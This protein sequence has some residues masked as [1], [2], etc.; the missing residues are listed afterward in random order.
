MTLARFTGTLLVLLAT[1]AHVASSA[2][3][4]G[5]TFHSEFRAF[6]FQV[7]LGTDSKHRLQSSLGVGTPSSIWKTR[8]I[9]YSLN[10]TAPA[11]VNGI[12]AAMILASNHIR[13]RTCVNFYEVA[14]SNTSVD[15]VIVGDGPGGCSAGGRVLNSAG[16]DN[17]VQLLVHEMWHIIGI[18]HEHMRGDNNQVL[19]QNLTNVQ[20]DYRSQFTFTNTIFNVRDPRSVMWYFETS[21]TANGLPAYVS[22]YQDYPV[23]CNRLTKADAENAE[24]IT[25]HCRIAPVAPRCMS[26]LGTAQLTAT[27]IG[28]NFRGNLSLIALFNDEVMPATVT[29]APS[30][31]TADIFSVA[32][33]RGSQRIIALHPQSSDGNTSFLVNVTWNA[34][35]S[36]KTWCAVRVNIAADEYI[37]NGI[38]SR[39][40]NVCSGHGVCNSF[41]YPQCSCSAGYGGPFCEGSTLCPMNVHWDLEPTEVNSY[42]LTNDTDAKYMPSPMGTGFGPVVA[43]SKSFS[44][45]SYYIRQPREFSYY[46][47]YSN[48][49]ATDAYIHLGFVYYFIPKGMVNSIANASGW[50]L[51]RW[52]FNWT[53]MTGQLFIENQYVQT[54]GF[55]C[56][57]SDCSV[58]T[59]WLNPFN[60]TL[61]L[62]R[63]FAEC[64]PSFTTM[65]LPKQSALLGQLLA[66]E[67]MTLR[68]ETGH[69]DY[70]WNV[71]A[72]RTVPLCSV[73]GLPALTANVSANL[74]SPTIADV[75][76]SVPRAALASAK[77]VITC[78]PT[79]DHLLNTS[80]G[81]A[82]GI[83]KSLEVNGVCEANSTFSGSL[84]GNAMTPVVTSARPTS[85]F[86]EVPTNST[87]NNTWMSVY[88]YSLDSTA[89]FD[90]MTMHTGNGYFQLPNASSTVINTQVTNWVTIRDSLLH[91]W[92]IFNWSTMNVTLTYRL[93]SKP[94]NPLGGNLTFPM[95]AAGLSRLDLRINGGNVGQTL[96]TVVKCT[97]FNGDF[98]AAKS[99]SSATEAPLTTLAPLT[100][101][102]PITTTTAAPVTTQAPSTT[103]APSTTAVPTTQSPP[104]TTAV[105]T[106]AP[107]YGACNT[108]LSTGLFNNVDA[109]SCMEPFDCH[110]TFCNCVGSPLSM[111]CTPF[112]TNST[113]SQIQLC[114]KQAVTCTLNA[115][116]NAR[117]VWD[118]NC[119]S[120]G[121]SL[122]AVYSAYYNNRSVSNFTDACKADMCA[123]VTAGSSSLVTYI[124][125]DSVCT[126][127]Q[128]PAP[129]VDGIVS[130]CARPNRSYF[131]DDLPVSACTNVAS[132][133]VTYCGCLGGT[134]NATTKDCTSP[135]DQPSTT[136]A[137]TCLATAMNCLVTSAL[138]TYVPGAS[139]LDPNKCL[140]W[141]VPIA[142]DYAAYYAATE[143]SSTQLVKACNS[144]ACANVF[145]YNRSAEL[146]S[147]CAFSSL[148]GRLPTFVQYN[149]CPYSCPDATCATSLSSCGCT[150]NATITSLSAELSHNNTPTLDL[151]KAQSFRAYGTYGIASGNC[152]AF[153]F[154]SLLRFAWALWTPSGTIVFAVNSSLLSL[155]AFSL[156]AN[157]TYFLNLTA[158]GLVATQVS[159]RS[160]SFSA[161]APTP[162]VSVSG[163]ARL[164][165]NSST[166]IRA[167]IALHS[168]PSKRTRTQHHSPCRTGRVA[169]ATI[170]GLTIPVGSPVGSYT[171]TFTYRGLYNSSL[172][173]T[174]VSDAI[175]IVRVFY[176]GTP[177]S[178]T[179]TLMYLSS[180]RILLGSLVQFSGNVT[181]SW[182]VNGN[183]VS[184]ASNIGVD[185]TTL[186]STPLADIGSTSA[187]VKNT[188]TLRVASAAN[189]ELYGEASLTI[190][191]VEQ[192]NAALTVVRDPNN[193]A[194]A[195]GLTDK[196]LF[197]A[198]VT[199]ALT[200]TTSPSGAIIS[201]ALSFYDDVG[202]KVVANGL[203]ATP[204][205]S[206]LS[207]TAPLFSS[208]T[209][210]SIC[211]TFSVIVT[212]NGIT[213]ATA[214]ATFNITKPDLAAA[215]A[216][217]L[218][219]A[220]SITDPALAASAANT[221]RAL[222]AQSTNSTQAQ[223]L[224]SAMI[225][226]LVNSVSNTSTL[227]STEQASVFGSIA[228]ALATQ[229]SG[230]K[231]EL[232]QNVAAVVK[233]ALKSS[234]FDSANIALAADAIGAMDSQTAGDTSVSLAQALSNDESSL[235]GELKR[236]AVGGIVVTAVRQ[237]GGA[238]AGLVVI[239]SS[240]GASLVLPASFSFAGMSSDTVYGVA[241]TIL[242]TN[243]YGNET[244]TGSIQ[245]MLQCSRPSPV[246]VT[247]LT[248]PIVL[249]I[250]GGTGI[251]RYYRTSDLVWTSQGLTSS[252]RNGILY[253]STTHL[254]AFGSFA[255][256]SA[257]ALAVSVSVLF[258][259][260]LA[261]LLA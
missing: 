50:K 128:L 100:T 69:G 242:T 8:D 93:A 79:S 163:T 92:M 143:K 19:L 108:N 96:R 197:T 71:S 3:S 216:S 175:P 223:A 17:Q 157:Q 186:T 191:I 113:A 245:C 34:S 172:N 254:T 5:D 211:Q 243:P 98:E 122:T 52:A 38:G 33:T 62:D 60:A 27:T 64:S 117:N 40:K 137:K 139:P 111:T 23:G 149:A 67:T 208:Q 121:D 180:Q 152:S 259:A 133:V 214:N 168:V 106:P 155:P 78:T 228:S 170:A 217:E 165:S 123:L 190:V 146:S 99:A 171:I 97:P 203:P 132:C 241:T 239:D 54:Y 2:A 70:A 230:S 182:S 16:C 112:A 258:L 110:V 167:T 29:G 53:A 65:T 192:F 89:S 257:S 199:P 55:S 87:D 213:A 24:F 141:S 145:R 204:S 193:A 134:W 144:S 6:T 226:M 200:T 248:D 74:V 25:Q 37:C 49:T 236:I 84:A 12:Q 261:Q 57:G 202:A 72:L 22:Q 102:A 45:N 126:L 153:D 215:A 90:R 256:S 85:I 225:G 176:S 240:S 218:A 161:V 11:V 142:Q 41:T 81:L 212:L 244:T 124:N 173:L 221:L 194:F 14:L 184:S 26:N 1:A 43:K 151:T 147:V 88:F 233:N 156:A 103:S 130:G 251:C 255:T 120:W 63:V 232:S 36:Q 61:G 188:V 7:S 115:A 18:G 105:P 206:S 174:V 220:G 42:C 260:F 31:A 131:A 56:T 80:L 9:P 210:Q 198:A 135:S 59:I 148:A 179:P 15:K 4:T 20:T 109:L 207:A 187:Q 235:I 195:T 94:S 129:P 183:S 119:R 166:V 224:G 116:L 227:S 150:A 164:S 47:Y 160:W 140:A 162:T 114:A 118:K 46:L 82:P 58:K 169:D 189:Q 138:D 66:N 158:T 91:V 234:T 125:I 77:S 28:K 238:L 209:A 159:R 252:I 86:V 30:T 247:G 196:L 10:V 154:N 75:T 201:Y 51:H 104:A 21:F 205:G 68:F 229:S 136:A 253:C 95:R 13:N 107:T 246:S 237:T 39:D 32:Y 44:L 178:A 219:K 231:K 127:A 76:F 177:L 35:T 250:P 73:A 181:Y 249:A 185:A 101:Q 83:S 222:M 48:A